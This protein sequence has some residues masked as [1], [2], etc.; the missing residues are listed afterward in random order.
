MEDL[1]GRVAGGEAAWP[2]VV[3]SECAEWDQAQSLQAVVDAKPKTARHQ[4]HQ[5]RESAVARPLLGL[6]VQVDS[7][8]KQQKR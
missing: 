5:Q 7:L 2:G 3:A 4:V 6:R 8:E 1:A